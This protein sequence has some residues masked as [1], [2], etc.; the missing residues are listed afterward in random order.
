MINA[1]RK[2]NL[3]A[4]R[5]YSI[6]AR[7]QTIDSAAKHQKLEAYWLSLEVKYTYKE[8]KEVSTYDFLQPII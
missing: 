5:T 4:I 7:F 3:V 1:D 6:S 8:I 2:Y